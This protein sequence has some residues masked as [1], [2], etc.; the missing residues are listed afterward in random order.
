MELVVTNCV[1]HIWKT[2]S[3]SYAV[4]TRQDKPGEIPFC[5][6]FQPLY[7][8]WDYAG[9]SSSS[10]QDVLIQSLRGWLLM[11]L[12]FILPKALSDT[13]QTVSAAFNTTIGLDSVK[14]FVGVIAPNR[15]NFTTR[16]TNNRSVQDAFHQNTTQKNFGQWIQSYLVND[17]PF[18]SN[19]ITSFTILMWQPER[20]R[21]RKKCDVSF[22]IFIR[23]SNTL[24]LE[25]KSLLFANVERC[26][27]N[28]ERHNKVP[29]TVPRHWITT[30]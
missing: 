8:C 22:V 11:L 27:A 25:S 30:H 6:R 7:Q 19:E 14:F 26:V 10:L 23:T 9:T 21:S 17:I 12:D 15:W 28:A 20:L 24:N 18:G 1:L 3:S 5:K 29:T 2:E 13:I 16:A 4:H